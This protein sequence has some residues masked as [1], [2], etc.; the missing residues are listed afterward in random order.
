MKLLG[1]YRFY[2]KEHHVCL[3]RRVRCPYRSVYATSSQGILHE[4]AVPLTLSPYVF[5]LCR[6][7][8]KRAPIRTPT[9]SLC[10]LPLC[11]R[12]VST[13]PHKRLFELLLLSTQT[14]ASIAYGNISDE[15]L[16][17]V[18]L[19]VCFSIFVCTARSQMK[20]YS[21]LLFTYCSLEYRKV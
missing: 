11:R 21:N 20:F 5:C 13:T 7:V 1:K 4:F 10:I 2:A 12:I 15:I 18:T 16:S 14:E 3:Y 6:K 17:L 9:V 19:H 8:S